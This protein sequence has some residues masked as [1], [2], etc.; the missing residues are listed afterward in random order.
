MST[1]PDLNELIPLAMVIAISPLSVIPG[2]LVLS[3]PRP[4]PTSLAFL[5]GWILGILL[6][7][8]AFVGAADVSNDGLDKA[9]GW[10][11]YLRIGIGLALIAFALNRWFGRNGDSTHNPKWMTLMTSAGPGRAFLTAV[12]LSVANLKVFAMCAAAGMAIGTAALGRTGAW[13][14]VVVFTVLSTSSVAVPVLAYQFAGARL[15][16]PLLRVRDWMDRNHTA[17]VVGILLVIGAG[18]VYKGVH[19]L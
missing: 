8:A 7:T 14:A 15:D 1:S 5:A 18:L 17:L 19:A 16:A 2:I 11:P 13:Q 9:P 6:V 10:G 3:T 12:A 4:K